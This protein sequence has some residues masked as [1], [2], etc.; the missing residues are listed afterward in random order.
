MSKKNKSQKNIQIYKEFKPKTINQNSYVRDI[1]ENDVIFCTG[2]AGCGKAQPLTSEIVTPK[3][4]VKLGTLKVGDLVS[5]PDGDYTRILGIYNQGIKDVYKITF[6]DETSTLC[7]KEHLWTVE[8]PDNFKGKKTF[9]LEE[10]MKK[11]IKTKNG[12]RKFKIPLTSPVFFS[13]KNVKIDPYSLGVLIGDG[14]LRGSIRFSSADEEIIEYVSSKLDDT[15]SVKTR[16]GIDYAISKNHTA[17]QK[18][19]YIR[20][21]KEYGLYGKLSYQKFIPKDYLI[22]SE[23]IRLEVL[24]GL[25][26]TDGSITTEGTIEFSTTSEQ[27][28]KD[29]L[30][31][32]QSLGGVGRII[33]RYTHYTYL[34][35]KKTGRKSYRVYIKFNNDINPF[36]LSRK[37]D[38]LL[39]R[40]KY[41]PSRHIEKIEKVGKEKCACIYVDSD[42]HLY[43][44]ND[45]I[46]THNTA[47]AVGLACSWLATGKISK[48]II[49]RPIVETG[50]K[51]LGFLPGSMLE[52]VHPYLI[53]ILDEMHQYFDPFTVED[54]IHNEV[55]E[56]APLEYMRGRN[57][58]NCFMILD[59]A[60]NATF[61]QLKMFMTRIGQESKCVINGDVKQTDLHTEFNAL[62]HCIDKL[63][64]VDG[65]A[66]S[67]L[68]HQDI[69]RS[70]I[71]SRILTKLEN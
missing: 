22:N 28:S 49:T 58:H 57:F 25:L 68:T 51:G 34:N 39:E 19:R 5:T 53:P 44:T 21:L 14:C 16:G 27:L 15:Y 71:I 30:F 6:S 33:E 18:N 17:V 45:F 7:C 12:K 24:Q 69:L 64:D 1:V 41:F 43:M 55:V 60:Q 47:V 32:V 50:R 20:D 31:L 70:G 35:E 48:M 46:V 23:E 54:L 62:T 13:K 9:S 4:L 8:S 29:I 52:K 63:S 36:K 66:I 56:I 2:P 11:G 10:I 26:D 3:G 37:S 67:V 38:R 61:D 59:E 40:K 42:D 65:V